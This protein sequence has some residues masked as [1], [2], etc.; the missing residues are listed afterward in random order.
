MTNV[1]S[2]LRPRL[3]APALALVL[4][5]GSALAEVQT[6]PAIAPDAQHEVAQMGK[7]LSTGGF[8]FQIHTI[9][10]YVDDNGQPL[11]IFHT[12]NA[13][14][15]R[16]DRLALTA[17]GDDGTTKITYD[18][19]NLTM[20]SQETNNYLS[21]AVS[22]T[23]EDV[24][25]E[26]SERLDVDFPLADLLANDPAKAFLHGVIAGRVVGTAT[27]DGMSCLHMIFVQPP[28]IELELWAEKTEQAVP[29]RLIVTYRSLPGEP[30]F[31]AVMSDWK[32]GIN[33]ADSEFAFQPPPGATM[34]E[35]PK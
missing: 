1:L 16:P 19:K 5:G 29:R 3:L 8:S 15:R 25:R 34:M 28:G 11:H 24:L 32:L 18:G 10:E 4:L 7:T 33:P 27:V 14:V 17:A 9:R 2:R 22:G 20:Y 35:A 21:I 31:I 6:A 23:L 26:A 12:I 30:R 13:S